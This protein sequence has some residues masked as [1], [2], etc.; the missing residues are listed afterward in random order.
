M[1]VEEGMASGFD[2]KGQGISYGDLEATTVIDF[3]GNP[4]MYESFHERY[5]K[6]EEW[7]FDAQSKKATLTW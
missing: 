2:P 4:G 1:R 3:S 7:V 5:G 6:N